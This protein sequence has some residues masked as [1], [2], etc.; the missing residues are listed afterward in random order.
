MHTR[1]M[2]LCITLKLSV[3]ATLT[4]QN[5]HPKMKKPTHCERSRFYFQSTMADYSAKTKA[6]YREYTSTRYACRK[7]IASNGGFC[8]VL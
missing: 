5:L 1:S 4:F 3:L 6:L 8:M 2:N 7:L